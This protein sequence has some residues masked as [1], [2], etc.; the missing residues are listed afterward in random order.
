M[1]VMANNAIHP[2]RAKSA[3]ASKNLLRAGD[4]KR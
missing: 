1:K 4:G 2:T 3:C